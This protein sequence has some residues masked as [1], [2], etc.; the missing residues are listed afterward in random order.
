MI[1]LFVDGNYREVRHEFQQ[2]QRKKNLT[3]IVLFVTCSSSAILLYFV[4]I[5]VLNLHTLNVVKN[6]GFT[7]EPIYW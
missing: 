1:L 6:Y 7:P 4:T 3:K 2:F 5:N